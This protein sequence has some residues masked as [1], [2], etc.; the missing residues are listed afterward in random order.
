MGR[1]RLVLT[2]DTHGTHD[3]LNV[4]DGDIFVHAGDV[5]LL[6]GLEEL[7]PF[8]DFLR[9][10][11]HAHK[12]VIAGN[13][14]WCFQKQPAQARRLLTAARYLQDEAAR[15]AGLDFYGSPWQP[16]FYD[17]AFNL[18]RGRALADKWALIPP[19]TDVLVTH[20][21]P[22]G[23]GDG[24]WDGRREGCDDL[25]RRVMEVRPRVHLFGHIHEAAGLWE[26]EGVTFVN[27]SSNE[28]ERVPF[29][30]DLE[31]R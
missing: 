9:R 13:H 4:P 29:V 28:G 19:G 10:L 23:I 1:V 15:I 25:L 21:P 5:T 14:D 27:A 2:A 17:W 16:W 22:R 11:P 6:G 31:A 8:N 18:Q 7:G 24:T 20:G 30:I 12:V 26:R 3:R